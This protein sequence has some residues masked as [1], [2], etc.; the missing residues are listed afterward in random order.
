MKLKT[1]L[2]IGI[3]VIPTLFLIFFSLLSYYKVSEYI[4]K[5]N[6]DKVENFATLQGDNINIFLK[7]EIKDISYYINSDS[8]EKDDI[9]ILKYIGY[10][11]VLDESKGTILK[12]RLEDIK[13]FIKINKLSL[14]YENCL[15]KS[16]DK[17]PCISIA[18]KSGNTSGEILFAI[19]NIFFEQ[20]LKKLNLGKSGYVYATDKNGIILY[21]PDKNRIGT[22]T[23]NNVLIDILNKNNIGDKIYTGYFYYE[24]KDK[25]CAIKF[26]KDF[27]VYYVAVQNVEEIKRN[28]YKS[29]SYIIL[30]GFIIIFTASVFGRIILNSIINP[31]RSL[32][33]EINKS[34]IKNM[35]LLIYKDNG[36]EISKL[37]EAYNDMTLRLTD[38]Y[39]ELEA[40]YE[41]IYA[42]DQEL[43]TQ[44]EELKESE[45]RLEFLSLHDYLTGLY[46]NAYFYKEIEKCTKDDYPISIIMADLNGL[47]IINDTLGHEAGDKAIVKS[48]EIF[49][50]VIKNKGIVARLGGDEFAVLLKLTDAKEADILINRMR[51]KIYEYNANLNGNAPLSISFGFATAAYE[52]NLLEVLRMADDEMYRDKLLN[53]KSSKS[54]M[55]D[56]ILE[57][58]REKDFITKG[59]TDRVKELCGI[60]GRKLYLNPKQMNNLLLLSEVHDL[61]KIG[62]PDSILIKPGKLD[63][64][65]W[66]IMKKHSEKGYRIALAIP[67][68]ANIAELI[69]RH[70]ERWDGRGYPL[71]LKSDDIPIECRILSVV[72]SYDAMTNTRPYNK[73][74]TKE[75]AINEIK[76]C[77]GTQFD[78]MIA[79]IFIDIISN[80]D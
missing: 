78:P 5:E 51:E 31:I 22:F 71:G 64:D 16:F 4:L 2:Y 79:E 63:D 17:Y 41:E 24:G 40:L 66:E 56:M 77:S 80:I 75:E 61:G 28:A 21:H 68:L 39:S 25:F 8:N 14:D 59:H 50:Q 72:D 26:L 34:D 52:K 58:L 20:L 23:Q 42:Q 33:N 32:I 62:I 9:K 48:S 70:H 27:S 76:R 3:L 73:P 74:K 45:E 69:L 60:V 18:Y 57:T 12:G 30:F 53:T 65:E 44:F 37:Y 54:N 67:E 35:K 38:S 19:N 6:E 1:K 36:D 7:G 46:N 47:K 11:I 49:N 10:A 55:M 29:A 43:Q 15:V 13:N